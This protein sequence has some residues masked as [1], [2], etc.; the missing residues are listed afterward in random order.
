MPVGIM[1]MLLAAP[2][3]SAIGW[4]NFWLGNAAV[5]GACALLLALHAPAASAKTVNEPAKRFF[6]E[7]ATVIRHPGCLVLSF[8]FFAFACQIF[9]LTFALPLLL[10]S[11]H[12]A[13]LDAAGLLSALVLAVSSVGHISSGVL[14]RAGVPVW[15]NIATAFACLTL[16]SSLV[17]GG[18]LSPQGISLVAAL[19]LGIGGLAPGAI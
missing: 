14:L 16:C 11:T 15:I 12:G 7:V 1:L 5:A 3:L 8:T 13:S 2:L 18:V 19:A 17:C 10:T 6:A 9:S 4:R